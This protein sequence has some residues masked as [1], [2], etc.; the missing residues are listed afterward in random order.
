MKLKCIKT[1]KGSVD[2][3]NPFY[4]GWLYRAKSGGGG[5]STFVLHRGKGINETIIRVV[6]IDDNKYS[7]LTGETIFVE[8]L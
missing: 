4:E 2:N 7:S 8:V 1:Y 5:V 3:N 6:E